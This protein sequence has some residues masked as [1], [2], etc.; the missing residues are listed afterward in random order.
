MFIKQHVL[1]L[2]GCGPSNIHTSEDKNMLSLINFSL[3]SLSAL[4]RLMFNMK[5]NKISV[6]A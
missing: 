5:F 3:I 6:M 1:P 4:F 2:N